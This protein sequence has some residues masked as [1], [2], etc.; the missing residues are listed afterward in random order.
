M[1]AFCA[2][3][4]AG[5]EGATLTKWKQDTANAILASAPF[6]DKLDLSVHNRKVWFDV[7]PLIHF[8]FQYFDPRCSR[9]LSESLPTIVHKST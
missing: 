9:W 6:V 4:D 1:D 3:L 5:V 8:G 2:Q 7:H